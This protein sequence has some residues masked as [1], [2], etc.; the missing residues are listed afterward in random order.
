MFHIN[1]FI[2]GLFWRIHQMDITSYFIHFII[3]T[4][5]STY[6]LNSAYQNMKFILKHKYILS[7]EVNIK[8][9]NYL[10]FRIAQKREEAVNR[11]ISK[12]FANDK[13]A[14]KKDKDDR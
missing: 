7:Y 6:F 3:G 14:N 8:H 12:L 1:N 2:L 4:V 13:N 5:I 10:I 11:E 9:K